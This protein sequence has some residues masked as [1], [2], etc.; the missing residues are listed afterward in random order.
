MAFGN[1]ARIG[2]MSA[3]FAMAAYGSAQAQYQGVGAHTTQTPDVEVVENPQQVAVNTQKATYYIQ[4][5]NI[6]YDGRTGNANVDVIAIGDPESAATKATIVSMHFETDRTAPTVS[7]Q[8]N[9][10]LYVN[11]LKSNA[12]ANNNLNAEISTDVSMSLKGYGRLYDGKKAFRLQQSPSVLNP[13]G[14]S[15]V[16]VA[17]I[18]LVSGNDGTDTYFTVNGQISQSPQ[19]DMK[20]LMRDAQGGL[21][22]KEFRSNAV[23]QRDLQSENLQGLHPSRVSVIKT[24]G[25]GF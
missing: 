11:S 14:G 4:S 1:A 23:Q 18:E 15:P 21:I 22:L 5:L 8:T 9:V 7:N 24:P 17:E 2:A 12:E 10:A 3:V 13:R 25:S 6:N 19:Y 16:D 20:R